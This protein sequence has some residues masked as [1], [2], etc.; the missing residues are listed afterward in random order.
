MYNSA[1]KGIMSNIKEKP[2]EYHKEDRCTL[3]TWD[4]WKGD[5]P[6]DY[7]ECDVFYTEAPFPHGFGHFNEKAGIEDDREYVQM[8]YLIYDKIIATGK[9]TFL[10]SWKTLINKMPLC[11]YRQIKLDGRNC[12]VWVSFW[13]GAQSN[14]ESTY[15]LT[16]QLAQQYNCMGDFMCGY[17]QNVIDFV[18]NGGD[19]FVASDVDSR[20]VG[21]LRRRV[22][23]L[24]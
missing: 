23:H 1:L 6:K 10:I 22:S 2:C 8:G 17:G 19:K 7:D 18:Q 14:A 4:I 3:L 21:V 12:T 11:E 9:P 24:F 16:S 13:N 5:L 15:E 20:A